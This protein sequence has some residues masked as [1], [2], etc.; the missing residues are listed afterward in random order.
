M[1]VKLMIPQQGGKRLSEG[2]YGCIF[3]PPLICRGERSP[4]GGWK[5]GK[6]G[7][8]TDKD[9]IKGELIAAKVFS[10]KPEAATTRH[11]NF[12]AA[13]YQARSKIL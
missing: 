8:I 5:N 1:E 3:T 9:D 2:A 12:F 7:K 4:R 10:K 13:A 11:G 6:L